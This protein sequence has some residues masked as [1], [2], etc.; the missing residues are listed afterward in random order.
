MK[1]L[2]KF[3]KKNTKDDMKFEKPQ[4]KPKG[5]EM[6]LSELKDKLNDFLITTKINSGEVVKKENYKILK[7]AT[8][9]Y[10]LEGKDKSGYE[11]SIIISTMNHLQLNQDKKITGLI[12]VS[13]AELNRAIRHEH[14]SLKSFLSKFSNLKLTEKSLELLEEKNKFSWKEVLLWDKYFK[15][16][17]FLKLKPN[18]IA[19]LLI[20]EQDSFKKIFLENTTK[21][22]KRIIS[23][24]LFFLNQGVTSTEMN[25]NSKN[26]NLYNFEEARIDF[27]DKIDEIKKLIS[28]DS[29]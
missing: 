20:T 4:K 2:K 19:L 17:L 5:F 16:L 28:Y 8:G 15:E 27:L 23:D 14:S 22:Q 10:R 7:S 3:F 12:Q 1:F 6:E 25:P 29:N 21:K 24:E 26:L 11:Y 13:E 9:L 18:T